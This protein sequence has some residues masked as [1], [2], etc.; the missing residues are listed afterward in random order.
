MRNASK[1]L[2]S[3]SAVDGQMDHFSSKE[4]IG[5]RPKLSCG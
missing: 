3:K 5:A 2:E 4:P 1:A